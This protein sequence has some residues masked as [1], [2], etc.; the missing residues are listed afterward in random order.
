MA[1]CSK[2]TQRIMKIYHRHAYAAPIAENEALKPFKTRDGLAFEHLTAELPALGYR[3]GDVI[4]NYPFNP[5]FSV[6]EILDCPGLLSKLKRR[7]DEVSKFVFE[8]VFASSSSKLPALPANSSALKQVQSDLAE[9]LNQIVRG[10]SIHEQQ[11]FADVQLSEATRKLIAQ[12]FRGEEEEMRLNRLLLEDAYPQ[13]LTKSRVTQKL[14]AEHF[15]FLKPNEDVLIMTTRPPLDDE[16]QQD[17]KRV[18]RSY[19]DLEEAIF[20]SLRQCFAV[21]ARSH[22]KLSEQMA[23]HL[24]DADKQMADMAFHHNKD[25]RL[26]SYKALGALRPVRVSEDKHVTVAFFV[27]LPATERYGCKLIASFGL[28]GIE[29]LIW[30]KVVRIH[31]DRDRWLTRPVF[32]VAELDLKHVPSRPITLDFVKDIGVRILLEHA[33]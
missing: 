2:Q 18:R 9:K 7:S 6:D 28:G 12:D 31:K 8:K 3:F 30:N 5:Q 16:R 11:R 21:C 32:V 1:K 4:Y 10:N 15:T 19:T 24:K 29:T 23:K 20:S 17:R 27:H 33:L 13:E 26:H 22:V 25:A 14:G